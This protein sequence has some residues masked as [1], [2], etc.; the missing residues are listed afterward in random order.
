MVPSFPLRLRTR[1]RLLL[2]ASVLGIALVDA[3]VAWSNL[4]ERVYTELLH[5]ARDVRDVLLGTREVYR[6]LL[7]DGDSAPLDAHTLALLPSHA[8]LRIARDFP[9]PDDAEASLRLAVVSDRPLDPANRADAGQQQALDWLR[10]HPQA[11]EHMREVRDSAGE[12]HLLYA[13][14]I[15]F[16][17]WCLRCHAP[18]ASAGE[19][20]IH[21]LLSLRSPLAPARER[22]F[23]EWSHNFAGRMLAYIALF[24]LLGLLVDRGF[25][26]RL[27][28]LERAALA[29]ADGDASVRVQSDGPRPA[30]DE[31]ATLGQAFDAMAAAVQA[32]TGELQTALAQYRYLFAHSPLPM[33][34][35]DRTTLAILDVNE[36][37]LA[38]YGYAREAFL[39]LTISELR[40][41]EDV[42][43]MQQLRAAIAA[44]GE[45]PACHTVRHRRSDGTLLDVNVWTRALD[46][47]GRPARIALIQDVSEQQRA[48]AALR[49]S[50]LKYQTIFRTS[51]DLIAIT[52]RASGRFLEVNDAYTRIMGYTAEEAIGRTSAELG[53]WGAPDSRT[54]MIAALGEGVRLMNFQ[55]LFRRRDGEVFPALLSLEA[56]RIGEHDC[57]IISA[58]DI[59]ERIRVEQAL[60]DS[61]ARFHTMI[62]W[63]HNWEYWLGSDRSL[64]CTSPSVLRISGYTATELHA[65]PGLIDALVHPEDRE[66]W[67][68][69]LAEEAGSDAVLELQLRL[70]TREGQTRWVAHTCRPVFD[71]AG[72]DC[73]RR[74]TVRDITDEKAAADEIRELAF[75]DTLTHLPNRRLL[76]DRAGR[77]LA[78][79]TRSGEY[80]ALLML[81]LDHFKKL[82]DTQGHDVGDRLL[83][84]VARRLRGCIRQHETVAR[85]GGDEFVVL[86]ETLGTGEA[87]ALAHAGRVSAKIRSVLAAPY[88]LGPGP[89]LFHSTPSLGVTLFCGAGAA[90]ET[91]LKQADVALYQ[92]KDAGR[93]TVRF[94][95]PAMQAAIDR[96]MQLEA[97]LRGGLE[98]DEFRLWYQPQVDAA[99]RRIG[100]EAL[101]RWCPVDGPMVAPAEFIGLAEETG[102]IVPIGQWVLDQACAQLREWQAEPA[103]RALRLA[104]NVSARQFHEP[105]F[106]ERVQRSVQTSGIDATGLKIELTE[107]VV[108]DQID[109]VI[110]RMHALHALGVGFSLDDFGTGYSS[111]SYLRRLPLDQVK[112]DQSFVRGIARHGE[113]AAI[114]AAIVAMCR[115]LNFA[116]IA[117]GVET[118]EQRDALLACG[119]EAFQS[120]LYGRPAPAGH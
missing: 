11:G 46:F 15:R 40:P 41:P 76:L 14:P 38:H 108:L 1:F 7:P 29:V 88:A 75:Y 87:E 66:R 16:D 90:V 13:L 53:T 44:A 102:L 17:G 89:A 31:L 24:G 28:Q 64:R 97:A 20:G 33:L 54:Q 70:L 26:R 94:F 115:T 43:L 95:A 81:D 119:C 19:T 86:L 101:L 85:L 52:E 18:T 99:G 65:D 50:Q 21:G 112:I 45:I 93:H 58:R 67:Q 27:A 8:L 103:T 25:V 49:L 23:A 80:G 104:V 63:T 91:L 71:G 107:S 37:A 73:G 72:L 116:V 12:R 110:G 2:A 30:Q 32:R 59:T 5:E 117:E 42:A 47:D 35:F 55:T 92:A 34:V 78:A 96:R 98:R 48:L 84:E 60:A 6:A 9:A 82:N 68:M 22:E 111:L 56:A 10:A 51:P 77:A 83:I 118:V 74:V 4:D 39:Q 61:E 3:L 106:V 57:F 109:E 62:D 114:V 113:D 69:H 36:A 120:Y 100:A 105:D 79:S